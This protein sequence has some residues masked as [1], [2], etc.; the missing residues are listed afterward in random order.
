[1]DEDE[2]HFHMETRSCAGS[3][4]ATEEQGDRQDSDQFEMDMENTEEEEVPQSSLSFPQNSNTEN[5]ACDSD[6]FPIGNMNFPAQPRRSTTRV[7]SSSDAHARAYDHSIRENIRENVRDNMMESERARL[8][9]D[10]PVQTHDLLR[11]ARFEAAQIAAQTQGV[12]S[13]KKKIPY[14]WLCRYQ[15]NPSTN[16]VIRF[17][18]D[19]I[20]HMSLDSLVEQSKFL[21][22][23][24]DPYSKC[25]LGTIRTHITEHMLHP[26]IKLALQLQ[27][28]TKMQS[29][30]CKCCVVNDVV[31]GERT[32]NP[33]A[34]RVYLTLC[35]QVST[36]YKMGE[37]KL[38][39][40]N[41]ATDK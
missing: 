1:M 34:M 33:Q 5:P 41:G 3:L 16:E 35:A 9:E 11:T 40:N 32:V 13:H 23:T 21:L 7:E 28:M 26:R 18:M 20:P 4:T 6:G 25:T 24:I 30:V 10:A 36:V 22:D 15:G 19:A 29:D 14:C 38:T 31:T 37:E 2:T 12:R 8:E 17:M 27:D 39:F